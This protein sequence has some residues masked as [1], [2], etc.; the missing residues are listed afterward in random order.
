MSP[1]GDPLCYIATRKDLEPS[2]AQ[3]MRVNHQIYEESFYSVWKGTIAAEIEDGQL[4]MLLKT[5]TPFLE[6]KNLSRLQEHLQGVNSLVIRIG[7]GPMSTEEKESD[8]KLML[9]A[10]VAA[11]MENGGVKSWDIVLLSKH[12]EG[13]LDR[14]NDYDGTLEEELFVDCLLCCFDDIRGIEE[15]KFTMR[16][17]FF[18]TL[19]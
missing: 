7:V 11:L 1:A 13:A 17:V 5:Y 19:A 14:G 6:D 18:H 12:N 10:L 2:Y 15:V 16:E 4:R 9:N 8:Q 3:V